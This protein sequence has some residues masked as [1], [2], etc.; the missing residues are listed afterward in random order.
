[1]VALG[2]GT[3]AM[4]TFSPAL[5]EVPDIGTLGT[6]FSLVFVVGPGTGVVALV[7]VIY[8]A[9]VVV[10]GRPGSSFQIDCDGTLEK[11]RTLCR[12]GARTCTSYANTCHHR[13]RPS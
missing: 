6:V 13:P 11:L 3:W 12:T 4:V 10:H 9:W 5:V 8:L 2:T 1:V 7:M